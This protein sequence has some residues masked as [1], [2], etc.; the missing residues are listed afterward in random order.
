M[1]WQQLE[2]DYNIAN[3]VVAMITNFVTSG[4]SFKLRSGLIDIEQ[5]KER[6]H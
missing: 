6:C 5:K 1:C 4:N 3:G 2:T